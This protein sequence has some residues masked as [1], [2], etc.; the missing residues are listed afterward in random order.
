MNIS[1]TKRQDPLSKPDQ[2][3]LGFSKYF[4]DHMFSMNYSEDKGWHDLKISPYGDITLDP[5]SMVLHYAQEVFEGLKAYRAKDGRVLL[6][7]PDMNA[8]RMNNS[9]KRMCIPEVPADIFVDAIKALVDCDRDWVPSEPD[10]SLYIRPFI[11]ATTKGLACHPSNTYKFMIITSPVGAYFASGI[12][13][14]KILVEDQYIRAVEGGTGFAKCGG[15]YAAALLVQEKAEA[16]GFAQVLWL[17]GVEKKYIEEVG[18]MNAMFKVKGEI[19]TAPTTGTVLPGITRDSC[20]KILKSWGYTVKERK[21][22]IEE[23]MA[24]AES[25]ELEEAFGTGTAAVI[26][27]IGL[28]KYKE[29]EAT[30][31]NFETGELTKRLYDYLTGIQWGSVEDSFDW[32]T[33][34][35]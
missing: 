35:K 30:I 31:N 13:P 1:V 3:N 4:S 24:Y 17:D 26:S 29:D 27:P 20:L 6:F 11:F 32:I 12:N 14:V 16:L 9:N 33:E 18:T 19:L 34:I 25:G 10:T 15:N 5:A 7:R 2:K 28:L 22:T 23:L 8:S 21:I